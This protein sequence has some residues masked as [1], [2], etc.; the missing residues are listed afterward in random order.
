MQK[1]QELARE[2]AMVVHAE[3]SAQ[4]I[5]LFIRGTQEDGNFI[6]LLSQYQYESQTQNADQKFCSE[7]AI[8][9]IQGVEAI[10]TADMHKPTNGADRLDVCRMGLAEVRI[11][12]FHTSS[13]AWR[14]VGRC[15]SQMDFV[16]VVLLVS[17]GRFHHG[18]R[19][20]IRPKKFQARQT[21]RFPELY[22]NRPLGTFPQSAQ[23]LER[24]DFPDNLQRRK[25]HTGGRIYQVNA[26]RY[27]L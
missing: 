24:T 20:L 11:A 13:C 16:P 23:R 14:R 18:R 5:G 15:M 17:A 26:R 3:T 2:N 10:Q 9:E 22:F 25:Q 12:S 6:E 4:S 19:Q 21:F 1:Y 8:A 7:K 27:H